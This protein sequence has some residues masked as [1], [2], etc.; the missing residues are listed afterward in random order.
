MLEFSK[1]MSAEEARKCGF[2]EAIALIF[3]GLNMSPENGEPL[4]DVLLQR[5]PSDNSDVA[6]LREESS[7][8]ADTIFYSGFLQCAK[9][10]SSKLGISL[11]PDGKIGEIPSILEEAIKKKYSSGDLS[12]QQSTSSILDS[13]QEAFCIDE[14]MVN[15]FLGTSPG[16]QVAPAERASAI[17]E[18]IKSKYIPI[19]VEDAKNKLVYRLN[20]Q[21]GESHVYRIIFDS[22]KENSS[23]NAVYI[24]SDTCKE[25]LETILAGLQFYIE[26]NTKFGQGSFVNEDI[27]AHFLVIDFGCSLA[28]KEDWEKQRVYLEKKGLPVEDYQLALYQIREYHCGPHAKEIADAVC[29]DFVS[30]N[31][32]SALRWYFNSEECLKDDTRSLSFVELAVKYFRAK[33][34]L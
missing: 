27:A 24:W 26:Q 30:S 23:K 14:T 15:D 34:S 3:G 31:M 11:S 20:H 6:A 29:G 25:C 4:E 13:I 18:L 1:N 9:G 5:D 8:I 33:E 10:L 21:I 22:D 32:F 28:H 16:E 12:S 7:D 2:N 17:I 19:I